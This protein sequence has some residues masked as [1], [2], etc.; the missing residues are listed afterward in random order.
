MDLVAFAA[1]DTFKYNNRLLSVGKVGDTARSHLKIYGGDD[2]GG[3]DQDA[4][5][6]LYCSAGTHGVTIEGPD[7]TGGSNYTNKTSS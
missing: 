7:H 4:N 6:T 1:V 5:L 2:G 3:N